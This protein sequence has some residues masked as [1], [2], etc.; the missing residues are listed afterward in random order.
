MID[1]ARSTRGLKWIISGDFNRVCYSLERLNEQYSDVDPTKLRMT[2]AIDNLTEM[3]CIGSPFTWSN[4]AIGERR[5]ESKIDKTFVND[6]WMGACPNQYCEIFAWTTS[7]HSAQIIHFTPTSP[8]SKPFRLFN[9]WMK[10]LDHK[11][12]VL[13]AWEENHTRSSTY[14]WGTKVKRVCNLSKIWPR[15]KPS[16]FIQISK[17][18]DQLNL[19]TTRINGDHQNVDLCNEREELKTKLLDL[20]TQK[21]SNYRQCRKVDWLRSGDSNIPFFA[22]MTKQRQ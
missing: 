7:N 8:P 6:A 16:L 12:V 11:Q 20:I 1:L 5:K 21:D 13:T 4:G 3:N 2:L 17:V 10:M 15:S 9:S 14:I 22:Q 18:A 19:M